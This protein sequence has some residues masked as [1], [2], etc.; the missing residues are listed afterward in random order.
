MVLVFA[1]CG[2]SDTG[3]PMTQTGQATMPDRWVNFT[4]DN[5]IKF[6]VGDSGW[7]YAETVQVDG[8]GYVWICPMGSVHRTDIPGRADVRVELQQDGFHV[9]IPSSM[10]KRWDANRSG[11]CAPDS[12][13]AVVD[14]H[15]DVS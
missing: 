13:I 12:Y 14:V 3:E 15:E 10:G 2:G 7:V 5:L 1:A 11:P 4:P 9:F 6:A 8:Q